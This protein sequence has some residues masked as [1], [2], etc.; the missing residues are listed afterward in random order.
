MKPINS[1]DFKQVIKSN[2]NFKEQSIFRVIDFLNKKEQAIFREF[3]GGQKIA[4]DNLKNLCPD[5]F[6]QNVTKKIDGVKTVVLEPR[7]MFSPFPFMVEIR[8]QYGVK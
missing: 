7:K 3:L 2:A 4:L 8:K 1:I 6:F 5:Y